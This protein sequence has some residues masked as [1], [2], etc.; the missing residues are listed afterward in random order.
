MYDDQHSNYATQAIEILGAGFAAWEPHINGAN[1]LRKLIFLTGMIAGAPP[2]IAGNA[3]SPIQISSTSIRPATMIAAR[4]AIDLITDCNPA[5][6]ISTLNFDLTHS[7]SYAERS[8]CLK[9][10]TGFFSKVKKN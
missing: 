8:G 3:E 7:K 1:V 6:V 4:R 2:V 9:L 10:M 5:L